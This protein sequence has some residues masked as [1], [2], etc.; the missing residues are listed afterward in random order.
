[1]VF[2]ILFGAVLCRLVTA[3][4]DAWSDFH[5]FFSFRVFRFRDLEAG[6]QNPSTAILILAVGL[7]LIGVIECVVGWVLG[8]EI[9]MAIGGLKLAITFP[10]LGYY[11]LFLLAVAMLRDAFRPLRNKHPTSADRVRVPKV[12]K[13]TKRR[14]YRMFGVVQ[15][16]DIPSIIPASRF[17][18]QR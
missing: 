14:N 1:M 10:F 3:P 4:R 16:P 2:L 7:M 8:F 17:G 18:N 9:L 13:F 11:L 15:P 5:R 12:W 6:M